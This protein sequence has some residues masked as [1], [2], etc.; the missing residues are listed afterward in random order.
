MSSRPSTYVVTKPRSRSSSP[1]DTSAVATNKDVVNNDESSIRKANNQSKPPA[2]TASEIEVAKTPQP[3]RKSLSKS[4]IPF[5][6]LP[7]SRPTSVQPPEENIENVPT[8]A[9]LTDMIDENPM[10]E[11]PRTRR[12][13]MVL[14]R[15]LVR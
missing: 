13:L 1:D 14:I 11:S 10:F 12:D 5:A 9:D 8:K 3:L 15:S 7:L 4:R 6:I 2:I